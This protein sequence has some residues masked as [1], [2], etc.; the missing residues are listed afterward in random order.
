MIDFTINIHGQSAEFAFDKSDS[1][2]SNIFLSMRIA[3]GTFF[4]DPTFG[5]RLHEI[6]KITESNLRLAESYCREALQWLLTTKRLSF[7]QVTAWRD[8]E[9]I[10]RIKFYVEIKRADDSAMKYEIFYPVS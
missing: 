3:R 5:S 10:D 1:L 4:I 7:I 8:E 6:K 2:M 9:A